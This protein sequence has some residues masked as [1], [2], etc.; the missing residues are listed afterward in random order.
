MRQT[1][2]L[3][4]WP[5]ST[6]IW[7]LTGVLAA[8]AVGLP[9]LTALAAAPASAGPLA[10]AQPATV[11][12]A[13]PAKLGHARSAVHQI[14][15]AATQKTV[16]S[17][18]FDDG[19]ADQMAA[20]QVLHKYRMNGTFYIITGAVG[21]PN[22]MT[23]ADLRKLAAAGDEIGGH[24]VSHL[25]L[26]HIP[27]AEA[28]RQVC[29]GRDLLLRWGYHVRSFAYPGGAYDRAVEDIVRDCGFSSARTTAG[30]R[31]PGC[32]GC[33]AAETFPAADRYAIR[34]T[35]Q[36]DG[37]WTV[38]DLERAVTTVESHGGGWVPLIF[39]HI[40]D[41]GR[42]DSLSVKTTTLNAFAAWLAHRNHLGTVVK[43]VGA[44]VG[45]PLRPPVG[46]GHA[47][48]HGVVNPSLEKS[49]RSGQV[50]PSV[51]ASG[52]TSPFPQCWM[53]GGYGQNTVRWHPTSDAHT[54][55]QAMQLTMAGH[56][57]GDAKLL[58]QFDL[59][60]CTL[61]VVTGKSYALGTWYKST[62]HTQYSLYYRTYEGEW[63]YWM[64][65]PFFPASTHWTR[66][67]WQTPP[68]PAGAR[69]LSFGLALAD[70]GSLTT[71]DYSFAAAPPNVARRIADWVVLAALAGGLGA[72]GGRKV[73]RRWH[74]EPPAATPA[75]P[76]PAQDQSAQPEPT[77]PQAVGAGEVRPKSSSSSR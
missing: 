45:G 18:T 26:S 27:A 7:R 67:S 49:S 5:G 74:R 6:T 75:Q 54:G 34:T 65:S 10:H 4:A 59:G 58:Q 53:K 32:P 50:D 51:E 66:A 14:H 72:L 20:A 37:S 57:S 21:A 17:F 30:L 55:R 41:G 77:R 70:N 16:V 60:A 43:T 71:D 13:Q 76:Q 15:R 68:L 56:R 23:R 1:S 69:G 22:Y 11:A 3:R 24:T 52:G 36:I 19:D 12:H 35:G 44:V 63:V 62:V 2:R 48:P 39:H 40:C 38:A 73:Y 33:R 42:C 64:S 25:E 47:R 61:P 46:G 8:L 29:T 9:W 31:S 28:R